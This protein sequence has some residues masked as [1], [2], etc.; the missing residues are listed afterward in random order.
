MITHTKD[1]STSPPLV[2]DPTESVP[3]IVLEGISQGLRETLPSFLAYLDRHST[4]RWLLFSDYVLNAPGRYHDVYAFT[5]VPGGQ[6]WNAISAEFARVD[7][8][9]FKKVRR[10]DPAMLRLMQDPRLFTVCFVV[11]PP[12]IVTRDLSTIRQIIDRSVLKMEQDQPTGANRLRLWKMKKL[13]QEAKA[14][15]FNVRLMNYILLASTFAGQLSY[16]LASH[17]R[18]TR[19]GWFSDRDALIDAYDTLAH[20]LYAT[21]VAA[22]C[23]HG[24]S[25]WTGPALGSNPSPAGNATPWSDPFTRVPDHFAGAI[26]GWDLGKNMILPSPKYGDILGEA[27]VGREGVHVIHVEFRSSGNL[28]QGLS[29]DIKTTRARQNS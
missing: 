21:T 12:G 23:Y 17:R 1:A 16:L 11:K 9:D 29:R 26:S 28:V 18:A 20:D 22:S 14:K 4:D 25:G 15:R 5:L 24:C 13:Q 10:V 3:R 6:Y 2:P 8:P 7:C 27:V 19:I